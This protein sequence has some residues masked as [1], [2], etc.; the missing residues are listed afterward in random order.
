[1]EDSSTHLRG[2]AV[3][4][5]SRLQPFLVEV[6][7]VDERIMQVRMQHTLGFTPHVA[8]SVPTDVCEATEKDALYNKLNFL[9]DRCTFS[10]HS[11]SWENAVPLLALIEQ[12]MSYVLIPT[13]LATEMTTILALGS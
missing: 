13:D 10:G 8:V 6:T 11:L 9:L 5:F 7:T 2:V 1:M 3:G 4:I 12:V